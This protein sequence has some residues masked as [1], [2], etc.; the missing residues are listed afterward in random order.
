MNAFNQM[1]KMF[2]GK[3]KEKDNQKEPRE[4]EYPN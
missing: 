4:V 1:R 2:E 3:L